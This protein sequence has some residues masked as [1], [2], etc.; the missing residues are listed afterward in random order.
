VITSPIMRPIM[1]KS[2]ARH[3]GAFVALGGVSVALSVFVLY[4]ATLAPTVLYYELPLMRDSAVLQAKAYVLGI[5][6]YTGYP[7]WVMLGKLFTLLPVGDVAYR[8][9]LSSA[10]YAA[11]TVFFLFMAARILT[12]STVAAAVGAVAFGVS[13]AFWSQAVVTE[14]YT[15]NTLFIS[16]VLFVLLYWREKQSDRYLLIAAFLVGFSMTH[17]LTS[18][19]LLPAAALFVLLVDRSRLADVKLVL[20]GAGLFVIGLLPYAYLPIRASMDY[21]P[22]GFQWGQ[23]L[24]QLYP[25]DTLHGFYSL[26]SGGGWTG[27]M[28]AFGPAELPG[29]LLLYLN[30]LSGQFGALHT[31]LVLVAEFGFFWLLIKDR[32]AAVLFGVLF[33]GWTFHALEYNIEDISLYFIPTYL[34]LALFM[35]AGFGALL[36]WARKGAARFAASAATAVLAALSLLA[37]L[38]PLTGVQQTFASVDRS[39]DYRGREIVETVAR[40]AAPDSTVL[41]HRSPLSYMVLVEKKRTD[42][43]LVNYLEDP[44]PTVV[45]MIRE[46]IKKGPVYIL[47]PSEGETSYQLGIEGARK[48]YGRFG[49]DLV[50]VDRG[51]FFYQ[52]VRS[53][54]Q[55][56]P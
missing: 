22:P 24:I 33:A 53:E 43:D 49:F 46:G 17:H 35:A 48:R 12:K 15:L 6:D 30:D 5:P 7:T 51:I 25:P 50:P 38:V 20:T 42:L 23:P 31:L 36:E 39:E 32:A 19:L 14:V 13:R 2:V 11:L 3:P 40:E 52:I 47:F 44:G 54:E 10:V 27:R 56:R 1:L 21:L 45:G 16:T 41:H 9:N 37:L 4:L 55:E 18:G 8:V 28:W 34:M 29:R 26:V